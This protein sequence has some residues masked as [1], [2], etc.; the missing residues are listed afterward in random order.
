MLRPTGGRRGGDYISQKPPG[1]GGCSSWPEAGL[2]LGREWQGPWET[3]K[4]SLPVLGDCQP[5]REP[6]LIPKSPGA[7]PK[8]LQQ[9]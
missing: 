4:S 5:A 1:Q 2:V 7:P 9:P 8:P 6:S 3:P